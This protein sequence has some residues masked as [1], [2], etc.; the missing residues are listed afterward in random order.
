MWE[1]AHVRW[2]AGAWA[3]LWAVAWA[4][5]ALMGWDN[6]FP[7]LVPAVLI[8]R[9]LWH[10]SGKRRTRETTAAALRRHEDPGAELREATGEHARESL[11]R[12]S[13]AARGL[14]AVLLLLAVACALVGWERGDGWDAAPAPA[15]LVVA[16]GAVVVDRVSR[17]RARRWIDDPPYAVVDAP[18]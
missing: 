5:E 10:P 2:L 4:A 9:R 8:W 14:A 6:A 12:S 17:R 1:S 7:L 18:A 13:W 11:A 16:V 15:L 3:V